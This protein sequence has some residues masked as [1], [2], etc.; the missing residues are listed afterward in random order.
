MPGKDLSRTDSGSTYS[1]G[2]NEPVIAIKQTIE[3]QGLDSAQ[4]IQ[5]KATFCILGL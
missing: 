2:G 1:D 3:G 5:S 4:C